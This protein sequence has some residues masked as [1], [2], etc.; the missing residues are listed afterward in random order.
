[1]EADEFHCSRNT[2]KGFA[3]GEFVKSI[4]IPKWKKKTTTKQKAFG[5]MTCSGSSLPFHMTEKG[6]EQQIACDGCG[7]GCVRGK[8]RF[9]HENCKQAIKS[10]NNATLLTLSINFVWN[11]QSSHRWADV[12]LHNVSPLA[13]RCVNKSWCQ[14]F[15][16]E[17]VIF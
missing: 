5:R 13:R 15:Y 3:V 4:R 9:L 16:R 10:S 14:V 6:D 8:W 7:E 11:G 1:M 17:C 12:I 2:E